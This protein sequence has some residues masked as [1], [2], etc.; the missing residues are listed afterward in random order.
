[1][2]SFLRKL[3]EL[4]ENIF[5]IVPCILAPR[6]LGMIDRDPSSS[7]YGCADRYHWHYKL[8]DVSNARFQESMHVLALLHDLDMPENP[9]FR[10]RLLRRLVEGVL[11]FWLA[12]R[13]SDGSL[14]E[15]YPFER[16]GCATAFSSYAASAVMLWEPSLYDPAVLSTADWL[17]ASLF[18]CNPNQRLAAILS[19]VNF[20]DLSR[21]PGYEEA[22]R[23]NLAGLE[24]SF[25]PQGCL[26]EYG[27]EDMGYHTISMSLLAQ[28]SL[29]RPDWPEIAALMQRGMGAFSRNLD[30]LGRIRPGEWSRNTQFVYPFAPAAM[31]HEMTVKSI[32][33]GA[34]QGMAL[35]PLWQDDRYMIPLMADYLLCWNTLA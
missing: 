10:S 15:V 4:Q 25:G 32:A 14:D 8:H 23:V 19:L 34:C 13:H 6:L 27:G 29:R 26:R 17:R 20:A 16:S 28:L 31:H 7:T 18:E 2:I 24:G 33:G 35:T 11:R 3:E 9:F 5:W 1:M 12:S 30:A 22:A 21:C